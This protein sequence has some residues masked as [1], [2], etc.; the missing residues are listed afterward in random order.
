MVARDAIATAPAA[1]PRGGMRRIRTRH[2][3]RFT[4]TPNALAQHHSLSLRARGLAL[5]LLSLPDGADVSIRGLASRLVE[6]QAAIAAALR[7][8]EDAGYLVRRVVRLDDGRLVTQTTVRDVP[9]TD[10]DAHDAD[11]ADQGVSHADSGTCAEPDDA[12]PEPPAPAAEPAAPTRRTG[13][14]A[15]PVPAAAPTTLGELTDAA[16]VL[17]DVAAAEPR[18]TIGAAALPGLAALVDQA[19]AAGVSA[20][21][22]RALLTTGLPAQVRHPAALIRHRLTEQMPIWQ[23]AARLTV[24]RGP[25]RPAEDPAAPARPRYVECAD[26]RAP[27]RTATPDGLC[28]GCRH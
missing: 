24:L 2:R 13:D 26:C 10:D 6:G 11:A 4:I 1:K 5:Y 20:D 21:Q 22:V 18:L 7:E 17:V 9:H 23:A 3:D 16:R 19:L 27:M 15:A 8:L 14:D 25:G 28:S 12:H